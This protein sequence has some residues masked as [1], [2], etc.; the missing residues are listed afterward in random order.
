ME[1]I[2]MSDLYK[3]AHDEV[4]LLSLNIELLTCCNEKC[5]H[6]YIPDF[7]KAGLSL[8]EIKSIIL[9]FRKLGGLNLT[10]T[11]GEIFLRND[12]FEIIEY[13]RSLY[14][15]VF[16]LTNAT[17]ITDETAKKLRELHISEISVSIYS[18][19]EDI[20]DAI[21]G[22]KGSLIKTLNGIK[23]A[24]EYKIPIVVKTPLMNLNRYDYKSVKIFCDENNYKFI[25]STLIFSKSNGDRAPKSLSIPKEEMRNILKD[26]K[27]FE[28]IGQTNVFEEAC[29]SL[30]YMLAIDS[31]G[32]IYPCNSFYYKLGSIKKHKLHEI[33]KSK[34]LNRI[35][36]IKKTDLYSCKQCNLSEVCNR[37]PGLAFLEDKNI[38]G[39]SSS[40]KLVAQCRE[41][42]HI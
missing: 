25:A 37:C 42:V 19:N 9:E 22:V 29:G 11:G 2:I 34:K 16:L 5:M 35:Q 38:F 8:N 6:C 32:N 20:H 18:M 28:P 7:S 12:I 15:R 41:L 27:K 39:C 13:A 23:N 3:E 33:W 17:L 40:A 24:N 36:N 30:K 4:I 10:L 21:T 31:T 1:E 14:L 26:I